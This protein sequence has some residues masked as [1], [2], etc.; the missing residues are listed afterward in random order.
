VGLTALNL[1]RKHAISSS[2]RQAGA[3][4]VSQPPGAWELLPVMPSSLRRSSDPGETNT[5][6]FDMIHRRADALKWGLPASENQV[7]RPARRVFKSAINPVNDDMTSAICDPLRPIL[8]TALDS[9]SAP[10]DD[11]RRPRL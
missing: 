6:V 8:Q 1:I 9:F 4:L 11:A 3:R 2:S 7:S 5:N 10:T